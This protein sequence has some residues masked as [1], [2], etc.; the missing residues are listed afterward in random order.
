[1][2][3]EIQKDGRERVALCL[4]YL[5]GFDVSFGGK[6]REQRRGQFARG[7]GRGS[8]RRKDFPPRPRRER[9]P[10]RRILISIKNVGTS[11][12]KIS[13]V[14]QPV[15]WGR[16]EVMAGEEGRKNMNGRKKSKKRDLSS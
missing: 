8:A 5:V 6:N 9:P 14:L 10:R 1:L 16:R 15:G 12:E 13:E 2:V 3:G 11:S 7:G 4:R